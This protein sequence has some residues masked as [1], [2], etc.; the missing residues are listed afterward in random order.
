MKNSII[1]TLAIIVSGI[2]ATAMSAPIS[3]STEFYFTHSSAELGVDNRLK[4]TKFMRDLGAP[5][6]TPIRITI[7]GSNDDDPLRPSAPFETGEDL[8]KA[9]AEHIKEI[10]AEQFG[11]P[12]GVFSIKTEIVKVLPE[13]ITS[14]WDRG[15]HRRATL[16]LLYTEDPSLQRQKAAE[17]AALKKARV[18]AETASAP[19]PDKAVE[20]APDTITLTVR[21]TDIG[22]VFE[23]LSRQ[24]KL[25][26]LLAS[27]VKGQVSVSLYNVSLDFAV[28]NIAD[29]AGYAVEMRNGAYVILE[30]KDVGQSS[31]G[32]A[33]QIKAFRIHYNSPTQLKEI[34]TKYLSRFGKLTVVQERNSVIVEDLPEYVAV[35]EEIL[36]IIDDQPKQIMIEAKM[37]EITLEDGENFGINWSGIFSEGAL[38]VQGFASTASPGFFAEVASKDVEAYLNAL[39]SRGRVRTLATPKLLAI[40]NQESSVIIGDRIGY[41]VTTTINN[42]TSESVEFLESGVILKVTP[43]VDWQNRIIMKIHPE[44]STG[45]V[46]DGIPSQSTTEVST[47]VVAADGQSVFIGGLIKS[48]ETQTVSGVPLLSKLPIVGGLFRSKQNFHSNTETV[49]LITP[50]LVTDPAQTLLL[51]DVSR[52]RSIELEMNDNVKVLD[53]KVKDYVEKQP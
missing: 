22:Q 24:N 23:M 26:I 27:G 9:R 44:V 8:S 15:K 48:Q 41:K 7:L 38:G 45:N 25:N 32:G 4:L 50:R 6:I 14:P 37:L 20:K 53:Q 33:T 31:P 39:N 18:P 19:T 30:R 43:S 47:Q 35:I 52:S 34:L 28:R 1:L 2:A 40:E 10:L 49:V 21:N 3:Q 42:V 13:Q 5:K 29:L 46:A 51:D 36:R 16:K 12:D 11:W 17:A